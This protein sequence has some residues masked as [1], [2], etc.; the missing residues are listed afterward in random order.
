[1]YFTKWKTKTHKLPKPPLTRNI[2]I[3]AFGAG[4][5]VNFVKE[6]SLRPTKIRSN[7]KRSC[8]LQAKERFRALKWIYGVEGAVEGDNYTEFI[9]NYN[10]FAQNLLQQFVG[11]VPRTFP[12]GDFE[13][14]GLYRMRRCFPSLKTDEDPLDFVQAYVGKGENLYSRVEYDRLLEYGLDKRNFI[15]NRIEFQSEK[16]NKATLDYSRNR[17]GFNTT[18]AFLASGNI[19]A[20]LALPVKPDTPE[21]HCYSGVHVCDTSFRDK[22][23]FTLAVNGAYELMRGM[24]RAPMA[25]VDIIPERSLKKRI[26]ALTE[27]F[28]SVLSKYVSGIGKTIQTRLF[29]LTKDKNVGMVH[30]AGSFYLSGDYREASAFMDWEG[31]RMAYFHFFKRCGFTPSEFDLHMKIIVFLTSSFT[32]FSSEED[33]DEYRNLYRKLAGFSLQGVP[34]NICGAPKMESMSIDGESYSYPA[35]DTSSICRGKFSFGKSFMGF[36]PVAYTK[37]NGIVHPLIGENLATGSPVGRVLEDLCI[38]PDFGYTKESLYSFRVRGRSVS[39]TQGGLMC[40]SIVSPALHVVGAVPHWKFRELPFIITGDD[41]ASRHESEESID[42]LEAEKLRTGM[43]PHDKEKAARGRKGLVVAEILLKAVDGKTFLQRVDNFPVR[44]LFPE[45]ETQWHAVTMPEEARNNLKEVK[46]V[47]VQ[48]RLMGFIYWKYEQFYD[49]LAKIGVSVGGKK[50]LFPMLEETPN[51]VNSM[52]GP[53]DYKEVFRRPSGGDGVSTELALGARCANVSIPSEKGRGIRYEVDTFLDLESLED[54]LRSFS[55]TCPYEHPFIAGY[56]V[57]PL[58]AIKHNIEVF[59]SR[60]ER[61]F[62]VVSPE[63]VTT[64]TLPKP[65]EVDDDSFAYLSHK[66]RISGP[67]TGPIYSPIAYWASSF[68]PDAPDGATW[69]GIAAHFQKLWFVDVANLRPKLFREHHPVREIDDY[70]N[71]LSHFDGEGPL[72]V[73]FVL[74]RPGRPYCRAFENGLAIRACP[75][76]NGRAGADN[77][78]RQSVEHFSRYPQLDLIYTSADRHWKKIAKGNGVRRKPLPQ[79]FT[80]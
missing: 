57:D 3:S 4:H 43:V 9:H 1:M 40:L 80:F 30:V 69:N 19:R 42:A 24:V 10:K 15:V 50:G 44:I 60:R 7:P 31:I 61:K 53:M 22:T 77:E 17:G 39:T 70:L 65:R 5:R 67:V 35:V 73:F 36:D 6:R 25:F 18:V 21:M 20:P 32:F 51:C 76:R 59:F 48:T 27:G 58:S 12:F 37:K 72:C 54:R 34:H 74:E 78:F 75:R 79:L 45:K 62:C 66:H 11:Q 29:P 41:N 38:F 55:V 56:E 49:S 8:L 23:I 26:P 64:R 2:C 33:R 14:A 13:L 63:G 71:L 68:V 46:D 16:S 47:G 52:D 28:V